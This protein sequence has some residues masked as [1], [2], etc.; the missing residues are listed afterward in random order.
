MTTREQ[1]LPTAAIVLVLAFSTSLAQSADPLPS[2]N[3]GPSKQAIIDFVSTVTKEGSP[4][5]VKPESA[6]PCSTTTGIRTSDDSTKRG[7]QRKRKVGPS[8]T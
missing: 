7:M 4:G 3:D 1:I 6:S 5:F 2:W 8:W